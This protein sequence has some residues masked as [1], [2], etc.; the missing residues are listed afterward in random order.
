MDNPTGPLSPRF[1]LLESL[2]D[3]TAAEAA[4]ARA[5]AAGAALADPQYEAAGAAAWAVFAASEE[6]PALRAACAAARRSAGSDLNSGRLSGGMRVGTERANMVACFKSAVKRAADA[7]DAYAK[8]VDALG[9]SLRHAKR[10]GG[11]KP[12]HKELT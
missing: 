6:S 4:L 1:A 8:A 7:A 5:R 11:R 10:A 2:A 3:Y 9:G 12:S